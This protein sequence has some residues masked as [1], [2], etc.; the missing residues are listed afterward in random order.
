MQKWWF[1]SKYKK[2][3]RGLL[4]TLTYK[5]R[6]L[7]CFKQDIF[8]LKYLKTHY[9]KFMGFYLEKTFAFGKVCV[10]F[11]TNYNVVVITKNQISCFVN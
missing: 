4:Y 11:G 1:K 7:L 8:Y 5:K 10:I 2:S 6:K 9:Q 3:D